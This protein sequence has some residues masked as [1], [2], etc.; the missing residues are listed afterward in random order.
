MGGIGCDLPPEILEVPFDGKTGKSV[1]QYFGSLRRLFGPIE[2][3]Q[4]GRP[5]REYLQ[6]IRI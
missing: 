2:L 4:G 6:M 3:R 5:H 1:Q